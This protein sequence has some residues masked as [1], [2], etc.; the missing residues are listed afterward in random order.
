MYLNELWIQLKDNLPN[1]S[2][3]HWCLLL[4]LLWQLIL[5]LLVK[6]L[7]VVIVILWLWWWFFSSVVLVFTCFRYLSHEILLKL[8]VENRSTNIKATHCLPILHAFLV[9]RSAFENF[10]VWCHIV[11]VLS[12]QMSLLVAET[13]QWVY[14]WCHRMYVVCV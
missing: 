7:L 10:S 2:V 8:W 1:S 5:W 13:S 3:I 6:F 11:I 14:K 9:M 4:S 12:L